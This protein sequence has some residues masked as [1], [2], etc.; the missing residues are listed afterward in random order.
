MASAYRIP[1][2]PLQGEIETRAV[3]KQAAAAHRRL[4]ELKGVVRT[5]PNQS[6]L[7]DTLTLQEAKDSSAVENIITTHDELFKAELFIESLTS[8]SA[9]EVQRYAYALREGFELVR[10][11]RMLTDNHILKIQEELERNKAGYRKLPGTALRNQGTA[12][13]VYTPPQDYETIKFLMKNLVDFIN[14]DSLSDIDNLVKLTIIHH[15]FES[16]HPFYDGNGRTGRIISILFL[17]IKELLD[18]PVLYLS[19][20]I[21]RNKGRYYALL[22]D[23]RDNGNWEEWII[24]ILRG[25]EETSVQTISLIEQIRSLMADYK[26]RIRKELPKIYSQDLLNNLFRHP[27]T[28]IEFVEKELSLSRKTASRYLSQLVDNGFLE[29]VKIGRSNFYLNE[30]LF[31]L[32]I[33]SHSYEK[34]SEDVPLI[35]S[36]DLNE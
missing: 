32:F 3:L 19:R 22:Q 33:T 18:L 14:D 6:I 31:D 11:N 35:E 21:I 34:D 25:I 20:Y 9:K 15:Q 13:T 5:I 36:V 16:I 10:A 29:L 7:I 2:L 17:V 1:M 4:A 30:P 23:V 28:K 12:E 8:P 26:K 27:Y 24:F